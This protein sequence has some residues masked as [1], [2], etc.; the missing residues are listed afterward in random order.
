MVA[1]HLEVAL[2][3]SSL[4]LLIPMVAVQHLLGPEP[5]HAPISLDHLSVFNYNVL[6]PNS[7]DGWWK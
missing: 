6:L 7:V 4:L 3:A 2:I 5:F 1:T